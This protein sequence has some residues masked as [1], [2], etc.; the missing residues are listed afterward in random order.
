MERLPA[1]ERNSITEASEFVNFLGGIV[2]F[3]SAE[4][5]RAHEVWEEIWLTSSGRDK[6]FLQGLI[7]LAA[8][9]HHQSRRNMSGAASLLKASCAKLAQLP[10]EYWGIE[11]SRLR[12]CSHDW[13]ETLNEGK[14][15]ARK[16]TPRIEFNGKS[17]SFD[18]QPPCGDA[19]DRRSAR[20]S[21][22]YARNRKRCNT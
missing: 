1:Q 13:L 18:N 19:T 14:D 15:A 5:F 6:T 10:N 7:Q 21:S 16:E 17:G 2:L 8:A 22:P 4:F 12:E 9:F 20:P 3:N 11:V